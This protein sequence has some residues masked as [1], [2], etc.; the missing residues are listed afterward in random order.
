MDYVALTR[1]RSLH[2]RGVALLCVGDCA[3]V[4]FSHLVELTNVVDRRTVRGPNRRTGGRVR[5]H[6]GDTGDSGV[7]VSRI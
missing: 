5:E 2:A 1:H 4:D 3:A 7:W 6:T